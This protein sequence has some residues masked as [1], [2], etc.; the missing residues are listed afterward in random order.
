MPIQSVRGNTGLNDFY[1]VGINTNHSGVIPIVPSHVSTNR[2]HPVTGNFVHRSP[3]AS[4]TCGMERTGRCAP[5][6]PL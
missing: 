3:N 6:G 4:R 1:P 2:G 5:H